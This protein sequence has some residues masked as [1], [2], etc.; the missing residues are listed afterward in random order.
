MLLLQIGFDFETS[1]VSMGSIEAAV[2]LGDLLGRLATFYV[3][4]SFMASTSGLMSLT[5]FSEPFLF[6]LED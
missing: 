1:L 4:T 3:F 6:N 2:N 5:S